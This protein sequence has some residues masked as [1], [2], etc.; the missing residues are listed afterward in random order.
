MMFLQLQCAMAC[1]IIHVH[2]KKSQTLATEYTKMLHTLVVL[3]GMGSAALA[4]FMQGINEFNPC[5]SFVPSLRAHVW[6]RYSFM[7][8]YKS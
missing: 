6:L 3:V 1:I 2:V 8:V 5:N 7:D 4:N